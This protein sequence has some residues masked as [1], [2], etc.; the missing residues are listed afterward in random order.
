[1][2]AL[3]RGDNREAASLLAAFLA[4]HPRDARGEDAAYLRV[5]AL[6]RCGDAAGTKDAAREYLRRYPTGFRRAEMEAMS[7]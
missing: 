7:R 4:A 3:D 6:Q 5:I 2:D 1:M